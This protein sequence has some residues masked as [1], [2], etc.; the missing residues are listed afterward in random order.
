MIILTGNSVQARKVPKSKAS[1]T[2]ATHSVL[3]RSSIGKHGVRLSS[4]PV[5]GDVALTWISKECGVKPED[6][7]GPVKTSS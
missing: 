4:I 5:T 1:S 6:N 3:I 2:I 7:L